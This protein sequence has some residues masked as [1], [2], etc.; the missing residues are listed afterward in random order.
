ME[1]EEAGGGVEELRAHIQELQQKLVMAE[2]AVNDKE[3]ELKDVRRVLRKRLNWT[4]CE[5]GKYGTRRTV[6]TE[7]GDV[8]RKV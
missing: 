7:C 5:K 4:C 3:E 1:D 8:A 6:S 2:Q